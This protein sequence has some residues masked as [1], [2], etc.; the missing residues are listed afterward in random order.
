MPLPPLVGHVAYF[1]A[2]AL[3][4]GDREYSADLLALTVP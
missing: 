2:G 4:C 3:A 1:A